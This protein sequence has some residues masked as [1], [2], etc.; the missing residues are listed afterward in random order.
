MCVKVASG[1]LPAVVSF[2]VTLPL[3][4][5]AS[6]LAS[7]GGIT[8]VW[9]HTVLSGSLRWERPSTILNHLA[10]QSPDHLF[11]TSQ[12]VCGAFSRP[13]SMMGHIGPLRIT[14]P[15]KAKPWLGK[16]GTC[17]GLCVPHD[18]CLSDG[19]L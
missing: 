18:I 14:C 4:E 8:G 1:E 16:Q 19:M 10:P 17:V 2:L 6:G 7:I 13:S 5:T 11:P 15:S 3:L 9:H 12:V